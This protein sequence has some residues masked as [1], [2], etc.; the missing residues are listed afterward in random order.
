MI[1]FDNGADPFLLEVEQP[2]RT[3]AI[4]EVIWPRAAI[5]A[6]Q[7]GPLGENPAF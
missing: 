3:G 1:S 2:A 6:P 7:G 4:V 5:A